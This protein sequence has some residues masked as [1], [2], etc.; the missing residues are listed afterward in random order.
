MRGPL[1]AHFAQDFTACYVGPFETQA[2]VDE[3]VA[4]AANYGGG[5]YIGTVSSVPADEAVFSPEEDR[6]QL[7]SA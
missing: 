2:Q 1:F 5:A 6:A 3:H 7:R 4:F